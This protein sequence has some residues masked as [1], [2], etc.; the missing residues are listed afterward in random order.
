MVETIFAATKIPKFDLDP[1]VWPRWRKYRR[2]DLGGASS[3]F[4]AY[5]YNHHLPSFL[6]IRLTRVA[7]CPD[8]LDKIVKLLPT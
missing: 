6:V 4:P 5:N 7:R 3:E 2:G 1:W 8:P